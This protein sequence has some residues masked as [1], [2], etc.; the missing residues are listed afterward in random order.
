MLVYFENYEI[1]ISIRF[2]FIYICFSFSFR[3]NKFCDCA[4]H[5][6]KK[7]ILIM[8]NL[9]NHIKAVMEK[10]ENTRLL[11][12][13]QDDILKRLASE[14]NQDK[15]WQQQHDKKPTLKVDRMALTL[16]PESHKSILLPMR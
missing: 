9:L 7:Q 10:E 13:I 12:K 16:L 14:I 6:I 2:L 4:Y 1:L 11:Q 5:I 8:A 15:D 3:V